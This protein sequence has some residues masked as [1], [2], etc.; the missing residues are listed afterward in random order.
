MF[1]SIER[2]IELL[3]AQQY[4]C[5]RKLATVTFLAHKMQKPV[6]IEGP[7][8][9]GKTELAK[10]VARA[11]GRKLLR[12]QCYAGLDETHALYEWEYGKQLLYTQVL[13]DKISAVFADVD[14]LRAAVE[15]LRRHE[16]LFFS[17]NFLV[18]RP[19]LQ[20]ISAAEPTVLLIDELDRAEEQFEAFLL[21][22]L[23]DFQVT[24]PEIGTIA[25]KAPPTVIITSNNTRDLSDALKRRCLHLF[26]DYPNEAR[27]L[28]IVRLKVPD[29]SEALAAQVVNVIRRMRAMDL[30]KAPSIS[31]T[32]DW[33]RALVLLNADRLTHELLEETLELVVKYERDT[34]EVRDK[35]EWLLEGLSERRD[36]PD[37]QDDQDDQDDQAPAATR[38]AGVPLHVREARVLRPP[39]QPATP[40]Q[41]DVE[42][43]KREHTAR[44]FGADRLRMNDGNEGAA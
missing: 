26:I 34:Q 10:A 17:E 36:D 27:E 11:L 8:G 23:S 35:A 30:R 42:R 19:I 40:E 9:V 2:T 28:E 25:C 24:I 37:H 39:R 6:L 43:R 22:V 4:I 13:R 14:D 33:T 41:K 29:V 31:E 3:A 32:L 7:A 21:E 18:R 38:E 1:D 15:K 44:Y 12:L 5:D 20:A 16:D